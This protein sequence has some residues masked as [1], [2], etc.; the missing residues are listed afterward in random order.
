[1]TKPRRQDETPLGERLTQHIDAV[2][3]LEEGAVVTKN[4]EYYGGKLASLPDRGWAAVAEYCQKRGAFPDLAK[5]LFGNW[6]L[7]LTRM[8]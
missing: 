6:H 5:G 2:L 7:R 8:R 3:K 4:D 1:M